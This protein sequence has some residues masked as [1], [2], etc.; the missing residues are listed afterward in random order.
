MQFQSQSELAKMYKII[1]AFFVLSLLFTIYEDLVID[2][3]ISEKIM[4]T[5]VSFFALA[6][7][8][9]SYIISSK[10][11][12]N[13]EDLLKRFA[14][15]QYDFEIFNNEGSKNEL[16]K[17]FAALQTSGL[18]MLSLQYML[19][20]LSLPVMLTDKD[21]KITYA[22]KISISSLAVVKQYLPVDIDKIVGS[23]IDV[24]YKDL[25]MERAIFSNQARVPYHAQFQLGDQWMSLNANSLYS[26]K[27]ELIGA[28]IDWSI[29][30]QAV[31]NEEAAKLAQASIAELIDAAKVGN[32]EHRVNSN[33]FTGYYRELA[34]SMNDLVEVMKEPLDKATFVLQSFSKGNLNERMDG[35]YSGSF[36]EI[37]SALNSSIDV[38]RQM[39]VKIK[40]TA[41]TVNVASSEISSGSADLSVRTEQQASNL[42]E[43]AASMDEITKAV[44][45]NADNSINANNLANNAC[46]VAD[47]GGDT[48]R[49]AI[50]AMSN[51]ESSSQKI[52]DIIGV[53]DE[54]AFQINL[55]AL[56]AAVEAARA[57]EAGKGFAV[58]ASEVR[59]LAGRSASASKEIRELITT[60]VEQVDK[61]VD[62]VKETGDI[63]SKILSSTREVADIINNIAEASKEQQRGIEEINSAISQMDETTQQ[64]AALVEENSA[65]TQS[66]VGQ[67]VSLNKLMDYFSVN[68]NHGGANHFITNNTLRIER[69]DHNADHRPAN[70][71]YSKPASKAQP[72]PKNTKAAKSGNSS[73]EFESGWEE[74]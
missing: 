14:Q 28:Y 35:Q 40:E 71:S 15:N 8:C 61:G 50:S 34:D 3:P 74:F 12:Q 54:I 59:A 70:S 18:N 62:L 21:L 42:E 4:S 10:S 7:Y 36:S 31:R 29:V 39:V 48:V 37:Q 49:N 56:N 41:G 53:I 67:A 46:K 57:G 72:S 13:I 66:L 47:E 11:A 9:Y 33:K 2:K 68:D 32:L 1:G 27:G 60:S 5:L 63:L 20:N 38:L 25:E 43:T 22:N 51:I 64:N 24:F 69:Q 6:G 19:D 30:T 26:P 44:K 23:R 17:A 52:S 65:A 73:E 16:Y 58:V 55:L 45:L